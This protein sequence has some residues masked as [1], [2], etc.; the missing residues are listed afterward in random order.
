MLGIFNFEKYNWLLPKDVVNSDTLITVTGA[1]KVA[2]DN[3]KH[4]V[5]IQN[6]GNRLHVGDKVVL[7]NKA[8]GS[9]EL[10]S[11]EITQ[12]HFL[13]YD[14][15]L[16]VVDDELLLEIDD[17][18]VPEPEPT[19][20]EP[21]GRINPRAKAFLEGRIAAAAITNQGADMISDYGL[22]AARTSAAGNGPSMFA[23][24]DGGSNRYKTGS[25]IKV[26]D[27]KLAVGVAQSMELQNRS[28]LMLGAFVEHGRGSYDSYNSFEGSEDVHGWGDLR[29]TGAGVLFH[30]NVVGTGQGQ[31]NQAAAIQD[32]DGLYVNA[33]VR[34]GKAKTDF[35]SNDLIDGEGIRGQ[36]NSKS[37]YYS[38]MAGTGYA[39]KLDDKQ[40]LDIYGR[41]TWSKL[42][43]D[44]VWIGNSE[45]DFGA[46]KSSRLRLGAR[47]SYAATDRVS[48]YAGLAYEREFKGNASGSAHGLAID[49]PSF[50]GNTGVVELG[51]VMKPSASNNALTLN[52]G[53]QGYFGERKGATGAVKLRYAF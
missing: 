6:D 35:D 20:E 11:Q 37:S 32:K 14:A 43:S 4:T 5:A 29:Y 38:V 12:G 18:R 39:W 7:I 28:T 16:S 2:L 34:A 27:F 9:P 33:V 22:D 49:Q 19:P 30:M 8:Q 21:A 50:K 44:S 25:H 17:E 52:V 13:I 3:T 10:T 36:Y 47:Y 45:L 41:Y 51:V 15:H 42:D 53:L 40:L 31:L 26:H 1:D 48:P 23:V 24:A 46:V